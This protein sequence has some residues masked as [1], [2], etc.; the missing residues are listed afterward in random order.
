MKEFRRHPASFR[1]PSGFIFW[2]E[3]VLYRQINRGYA[4]HYEHLLTSGLYE[5]LTQAGLLI[6][7][8][9]ADI[10]P[11]D[12]AQAY[13]VI[14]PEPLPFISYPYEWPFSLLK[15]AAL[16]T[17]AVQ[18]AALQHGMTLKDA[19]AY[20]IQWYRGRPV[21]IDTLSFEIYSEGQ[22]WVAYRQFC[23][24][25][26]A[27]LALMA[28]VDVRLAALLRVHLDGIPLDLASRLLPARTRANFGLLT[29]VHFHAKAQTKLA[30]TSEKKPAATGRMS[31][32]AMIGLIDSL[33]NTVRGL[34]WEPGGTA[35][36]DYYENTN[37]TPTAFAHK[38]RVVGEWLTQ[39]HPNTVWDLGA[40]DGTFSRLAIQAGAFT[41]ALDVDPSAVESNYRHVKQHKETQ[42]LPL[43]MDLTNPSPGL[44]WRHQ[45]RASLQARGP[46]DALL[47]LALIHHLAIGN[48]VPWE[49]IAA[50]FADL[51][52]WLIVEFIPKTDSQVQRL[53]QSRQDIFADYHQEG[54]EHAFQRH[55]VIRE[56]VPLDESQ[57]V[58]YLMMRRDG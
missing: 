39:L 4:K 43:W 24:H 10:E 20:N 40:N 6:P 48:N 26:L 33:E 8:E 30:A 22:P 35:W 46:A 52:H 45:E 31:R 44:G 14:R 5:H 32:Q 53:L 21:L 51:G 19:S 18:K 15:D 57:R 13:A 9:Q 54:F 34:K 7:H 27:P 3:G 17:L 49:D 1:D 29:H 58:L 12:P 16:T 50:F 56:R 28:K 11:A 41:V 36:G 2:H 42:L 38:Q 55:F 47:A 23:Q 25:F 37:Y